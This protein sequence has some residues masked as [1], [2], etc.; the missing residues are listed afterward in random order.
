[1][2]GR[3][4]LHLIGV[5]TRNPHLVPKKIVDKCHA[6][7]VSKR[8][9]QETSHL[10]SSYETCDIIPIAPLENSFT[11]LEEILETGDAAVLASGDPMFFGIGKRLVERFGADRVKVY[12]AVSSVQH[13]FAHLKINWDDACFL[14]LHGRPLSQSIGSILAKPKVLLLTDGHNSPDAIADSLLSYLGDERGGRIV[15]HVGENIG[16]NDEMFITGSLKEISGM[17]F[18]PL[19]CMILIREAKNEM[20]SA[21]LGLTERQ[22]VHS[23]GLITK[24]EVRAAVL[25]ALAL[26]PKSV[27]WDIGAGSGSVGLEA[28]RLQSD[29]LVYA[30]EKN[31][32]QYQNILENIRRF[33]VYNIQ[34]ISGEAPSCLE[35]IQHPDRVFIGGSG[36]NLENI[37]GECVSRLNPEGRIVVTAVLEKTRLEAPRYLHE[38]GLR[39]ETSTISVTRD[40]YPETEQQQFNPITIIVGRKTPVEG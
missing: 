37:I 17:S 36:G 13:L 33:D 31:A 22:I 18:G 19:N 6:V 40:V 14:S 8:I 9:Q 15:A 38:A 11:R 27:L 28:S 3:T 34:V 10:R 16:M 26:E 25:H 20:F 30:F 29:V 4:I 1:M 24:N 35:N 7:A 39:V 12:P 5:D 32:E 21:V 2:N 23:R